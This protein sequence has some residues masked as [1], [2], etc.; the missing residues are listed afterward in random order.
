MLK[1]IASCIKNNHIQR[2]RGQRLGMWQRRE[3]FMDR[4]GGVVEHL[5]STIDLK[6]R[7]S[8]GEGKRERLVV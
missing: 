8:R 6:D 2:A 4:A 5:P 1:E 3:K 7:A